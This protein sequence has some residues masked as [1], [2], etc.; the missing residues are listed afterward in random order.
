V[1]AIERPQRGHY[2]ITEGGLELLAKHPVGI[3][4]LDLRGMAKPGD[5][6]WVSKP[7]DGAT[8]TQMDE[9]TTIDPLDP[10]EQV[11]QGVARIHADVAAELLERLHAHDPEFF[12]QAVVELLLAM[13]YGGAHGSGAPTQ[14]THDG[15]IDGII[16]LDRLGLEKVYVQAKRWAKNNTV[17]RPDVQGFSGALQGQN[18]S[19]GIFITTSSFSSHAIEFARTVSDSI[20]LIDGDHLTTLMIEYGVGVQT[21]RTVP[22]VELDRDYF[23]DS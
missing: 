16:S 8:A 19:K 5:E 23:D 2:T 3:T 18:A 13:G 20:V 14:L 1:G 21:E 10:T 9:A 7:V 11:E 6:W 12:E 22:V 15:G 17:G 4:E